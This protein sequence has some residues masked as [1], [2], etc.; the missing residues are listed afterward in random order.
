MRQNLHEC[1]SNN[2]FCGIN[3]RS[4]FLFRTCLALRNV[5]QYK[6]YNFLK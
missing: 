1:E 4:E 3:H 6:L 2:V 5:C